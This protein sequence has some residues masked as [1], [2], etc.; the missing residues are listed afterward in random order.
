MTEIAMIAINPTTTTQERMLFVLSHSFDA[1]TS[2]IWNKHTH[3]VTTCK[4][5]TCQM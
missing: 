4:D 1:G 3:S 2:G 5:P